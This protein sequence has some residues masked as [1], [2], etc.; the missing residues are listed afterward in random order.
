M[1]LFIFL[2][3]PTRAG[4][5]AANFAGSGCMAVGSGGATRRAQGTVPMWGTAIFTRLLSVFGLLGYAAFGLTAGLC[6][7]VGIRFEWLGGFTRWFGSLER[8]GDFATQEFEE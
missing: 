3:T 5:I 8:D 7:F 6:D 1:T 4:C 2:S